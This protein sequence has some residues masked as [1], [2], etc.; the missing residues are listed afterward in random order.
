MGN[1]RSEEKNQGVAGWEVTG[2]FQG[3]NEIP[4]FP[5]AHAAGQQ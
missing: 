4:K 5:L 2:V 3:M 1:V